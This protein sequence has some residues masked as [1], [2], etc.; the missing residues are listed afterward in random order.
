MT[1]T[2]KRRLIAGLACA[3]VFAAAVLVIIYAG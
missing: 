2:V 1:K 3:A